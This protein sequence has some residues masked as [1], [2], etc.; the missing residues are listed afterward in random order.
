MGNV[1]HQLSGALTIRGEVSRHLLSM[2]SPSLLIMAFSGFVSLALMKTYRQINT[3]KLNFEGVTS[4]AAS[5]IGLVSLAGIVSSSAGAFW[6]Y[7]LGILAFILIAWTIDSRL[8]IWTVVFLA[9]FYLVYTE[10]VHLA[11][12]MMPVVIVVAALLERCWIAQQFGATLRVLQ[13]LSL[14]HI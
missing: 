8:A 13:R 4:A 6:P 11:Y 14:I 5:V 9:P 3:G 2:P 12:V 7:H 10:R 1:D